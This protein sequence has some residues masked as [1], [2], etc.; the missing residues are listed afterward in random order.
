[1]GNIIQTKA[2]VG[3]M[4]KESSIETINQYDHLDAHNIRNTGN[5][6][7]DENYVTALEGTRLITQSTPV[8][9]NKAVGGARF[10]SVGK[11]YYVRQNSAGYHQIVEFDY[12]TEQEFVLFE[13]LTDSGGLN[14]L[15]IDAGTF[16]CD[17]RLLDNKYLILNDSKN[18]VLYL[19]LNLFKTDKPTI[20]RREDLLL[21]KKPSLKPPVTEY[22]SN[23]GRSSNNLKGN[24][25]QFSTQ[26]EYKDF[27]TSV[28]S[29]RSK[30]NVPENESSD[31]Y[32][33]NVQLY[34]AL[35]VSVDVGDIDV[36]AINIGVRLGDGAWLLVKT[37]TTEYIKSL[38]QT[39]VSI[40]NGI[41]EAYDPATNTYSFIFYNDGVYPIIDPV[42]I[43]LNYDHTPTSCE[44]VEIIN[45]NMLAL[46]GLREGK[47]RPVV[48]EVNLGVTT[49]NPNIINTI[50][51]GVG[52]VT[53]YI[54]NKVYLASDLNFRNGATI[55]FSGTPKSGDTILI[56]L[57]KK[58]QALIT[59]TY[60]PFTLT[61]TEEMGGMPAV[62]AF[63]ASRLPNATANNERVFF[64][65]TDWVS[66]SKNVL[67]VRSIDYVQSNIGVISSKSIRA[68]KSNSS[69]QLALFYF[70]SQGKYFP[71]VTDDRFIV[72]TQGLAEAQGLINQINWEIGED[73]PEGAVSYQWG[74]SENQTH[75]NWKYLTGTIESSLS[76]DGILVFDLKSLER[77]YKNEAETQ[78]NYS[79]TK[80]DKVT[81]YLATDGATNTPI[82]YFRFP[83]IDLDI[84]DFKIDVSPT[85]PT[86]V[87][88]YL[89]VRETSL[90]D[91]AWLAGKEI[92]MELYTPKKR[93]ITEGSLLFFEIGEEYPII[94]GKH[95]V[96]TG[97]IK[98]GDNFVRGRLYESTINAGVPLTY[99]VEDP[100]FSD[101][102]VS[103]YYSFGRARTYDDEFGSPKDYPANIRYSDTYVKGS[104]FNAINRFYTERIYGEQGGETTSIYGWIRKLESRGDGLVALQE[105]GVGVIPV[106][107]SI[108]FDNTN[109]SLVA[110]SGRIFGS[111][112]YRIG[113][114]GVGNAKESVCISK[115][116]VIYFID[117]INCVPVRDSYSGLD[118][119]DVG[120]THYFI[121]HIQDAI[122]RG[123]KLIG[124]FDELNREYNVTSTDIRG[125]LTSLSFKDSTY[126]DSFPINYN[127]IENLE[128]SHGVVVLNP[129]TGITEY[130]PEIGYVGEDEI[131]F[132]YFGKHVT[133]PVTVEEGD[134]N[135]DP[136]TFV[137]KTDQLP[138]IVIESNQV[139][140]AGT[141]M[142]STI[143][144]TNGEYSINNGSWSN[145][146][147][148]IYPNDSV[149]VRHT[150]AATPDTDTITTLTI[151]NVSA[152]FKSTTSE[153][154][155]EYLDIIHSIIAPD[156]QTGT[157][158]RYGVKVELSHRLNDPYSSRSTIVYKKFNSNTIVDSGLVTIPAGN[159][160]VD[161]G[162]II[163]DADPTDAPVNGS[164]YHSTLS[165]GQSI[166]C[167]D[168]IT[169]VVRLNPDFTNQ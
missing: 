129:S 23:T 26:F 164:V 38:P 51:G 74:I 133:I 159:L 69:Y 64:Y 116:S 167:E 52:V 85:D 14:I 166:E 18:E 134:P 153:T 87:K 63:L 59:Q 60:G 6:N 169:R 96:T 95:S 162:Y 131:E 15:D 29:T 75:Q 73:A 113:N 111:V 48:E 35:K 66:G 56:K 121:N 44:S 97:S 65:T 45:G 165:D 71:I 160:S 49:Y 47:E 123:S 105:R 8:G 68:L 90:L 86:D 82:K 88:Y 55:S 147:S 104:K 122:N 78:V 102:Y 120:M 83:F 81:L 62:Y 24:L 124:Y 152:Q 30:R 107:K 21:A 58:D 7:N 155:T 156:P 135:P 72:K 130:T 25:F 103:N 22:L 127:L 11:A 54:G 16:F 41:D 43:E 151:G 119:I 79:F 32:G 42:E 114:Y 13:N 140:V 145:A 5:E 161:T 80:G 46:A 57:A 146:V 106:Y 158:N 40:D 163:V 89:K 138:S 19:D 137:A 144:I 154:A 115:D 108:I 27:R 2:L 33:Q 150:T 4:D 118:V 53:S 157:K 67:E 128:A 148:L 3:K 132:D 94:N 50:E 99:V 125:L 37:I 84:V 28:W 31:G 9:Q 100:N 34:N 149:K 141:N 117:P 10:E 39:Q 36:S 17:I 112:Q 70:D 91:K 93:A 101:N 76:Q 143:S 61:I 168:G 136:F 142:P 77:F 109:T 92:L 139:V 98:E 20:V 126:A 12:S 1:M 110:D